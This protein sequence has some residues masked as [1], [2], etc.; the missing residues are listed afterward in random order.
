MKQFDGT[1]TKESLAAAFA[2]ESQA[3]VR[4]LAFAEKAKEEGHGAVARYFEE[5]AGNEMEHAKI[6]QRLVGITDAASAQTPVVGTTKDNLQAAIDG[7]SFEFTDMYPSFAKIATEEGF[8]AVS[9]MFQQ[10][11]DIEKSHADF[12][13]RLLDNLSAP[14][15]APVA[16]PDTWKCDACG[17]IVSASSAPASCAVCGGPGFKQA[18]M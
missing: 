1:K 8:D 9:T 17:N 7:E 10:V 11:A 6:W 5:T 18:M 12:L 16:I 15:T 3:R 4:Y 14:P 2:G 13:K